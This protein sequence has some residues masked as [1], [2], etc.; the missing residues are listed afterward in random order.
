MLSWQEIIKRY[1]V[2]HNDKIQ[3]VTQPLHDH[4]GI[5]YF[6]YHRIDAEGKYTVLVDRPDW[7]EFYVR[8]EFF[9]EDPF[10]RHPQ[11][12]R[13][14]LFTMESQG[15]DTYQEKVSKGKDF[16]HSDLGVIFIEKQADGSVEFF[17]FAGNRSTSYL[18]NLYLNHPHLLKSF[19]AHFRQTLQPILTEMQKECDFLFNLNGSNF[20]AGQSLHPDLPPD[21]LI[22]YLNDLDKRSDLLKIFTLSPRE[23]ECLKIAAAGANAQETAA[24]LHISPRT[25]EFHFENIKNKLVCADKREAIAF[26]QNLKNSGIIF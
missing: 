2:R 11:F 24:A 26:A 7:A 8:E 5:S 23:K 9:A 12:Y 16:L 6:T 15:T 19:G 18:D 13:S 14:G 20:L 25:V 3:K 17:G 4:F 1:I 10:L 22:K 21:L